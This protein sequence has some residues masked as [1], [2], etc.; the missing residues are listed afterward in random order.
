MPETSR[1]NRP[2]LGI[3]LVLAAVLAMSI[4][5]A[6]VKSLSGGYP[7][8]QVVFTRALIGLALCLVF[9]RFEGGWSILKTRQPGLHFL[10]GLLI[11]IANSCF[12]AAIAVV[13]LG[14]ATAIFFAA[15]LL[16]TLFSVPV[17]GE[18]IGPVR[19]AAVLIGFA[20]VLVMQRP[21]A[22]AGDLGVSRIVLL[23]PLIAATTYALQQVMTRRLGLTSK[24]SAMAVYI[25]LVFFVVSITVGAIAG[26]GKFVAGLENPSL[27][28]LLRPWIWPEAEDLWRFLALGMN[29]AVASYC[30]SAAYRTADAGVLAPFEYCGLLL[31]VFWG[32]V[33]WGE[34][35]GLEVAFGII[36]IVSGGLAV[37]LREKQLA[38]RRALHR[39]IGEMKS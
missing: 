26:D 20:G 39:D 25:Q 18:R 33:F 17:L 8:H 7:L 28:F 10:R 3:A 29:I 30:I 13:P 15:P 2:S 22:N 32:W 35:P 11:V 27:I 16:I 31:A 5:D 1:L 23:L 24:A 37:Y 38:R 36:L 6:L 14:E 9:V 12:F 21:W 4:N 19:L 34:L